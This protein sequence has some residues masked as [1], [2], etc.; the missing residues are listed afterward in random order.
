MGSSL[1]KNFLFSAIDSD[2]GL[3]CQSRDA[4]GWH[5]VRSNKGVSGSGKMLW[6]LHVVEM[7]CVIQSL[8]PGLD[9][10]H[11]PTARGK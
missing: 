7:L 3:L 5:G 10:S 2:E 9:I 1:H 4:G 11:C 8:G 6:W